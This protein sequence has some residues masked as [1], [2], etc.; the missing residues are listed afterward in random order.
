MI[1]G[2]PYF[3][4]SSADAINVVLSFVYKA[5]GATAGT[6]RPLSLNSWMNFSARARASAG[7]FASATGN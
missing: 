2:T 7:V 6:T 4:P 3:R 1:T 5:C